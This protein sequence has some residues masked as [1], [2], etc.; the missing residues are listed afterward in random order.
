M[1]S[2]NQP[3]SLRAPKFVRPIVASILLYIFGFILYI[4]R[5][6]WCA[7]VF[8]KQIPWARI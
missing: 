2:S 7:R 3:V 1:N 4:W 6:I 5:P 8:K